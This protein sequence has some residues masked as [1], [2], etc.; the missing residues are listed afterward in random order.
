MKLL[1]LP[2]LTVGIRWQGRLESVVEDG[3]GEVDRRCDQQY[4]DI[5][6]IKV[7]KKAPSSLVWKFFNFCQYDNKKIYQKGVYCKVCD[8]DHC[9]C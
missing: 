8:A 1:C 4:M 2:V 7:L 3:G 9:T 5:D 6:P